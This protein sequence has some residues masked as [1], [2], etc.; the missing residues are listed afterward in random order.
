MKHLTIFLLAGMVAV[1]CPLSVQGQAPPDNPQILP[2]TGCAEA[3]TVAHRRDPR[4]PLADSRYT[5][6]LEELKSSKES[7]S[8]NVQLVYA[9]VDTLIYY[10]DWPNMS[11]ADRAAATRHLPAL[12]A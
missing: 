3:M 7:Q 9:P 5:L 6:I 4:Q 1:T 12:R 10:F 2:V 8:Y 11:N